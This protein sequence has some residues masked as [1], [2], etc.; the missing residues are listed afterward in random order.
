VQSG[1]SKWLYRHVSQEV[2]PW[3]VKFSRHATEGAFA[4]RELISG[5]DARVLA[6]AVFGMRQEDFSANVQGRFQAR[7]RAGDGAVT[8]A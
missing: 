4:A 3:N 5:K 7:Y 2:C 8:R 6:E 1:I